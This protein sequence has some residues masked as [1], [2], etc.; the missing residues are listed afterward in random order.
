MWHTSITRGT[1]PDVAFSKHEVT[2]DVM[3]LTSNTRGYASFDAAYF[4]C[5]VAPDLMWHTSNTRGTRPN[6]A[7][8]K[9]MGDANPKIMRTAL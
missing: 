9:H 7:Y 5:K 1:R 6:M 8:F 3:W 2:L 4:R